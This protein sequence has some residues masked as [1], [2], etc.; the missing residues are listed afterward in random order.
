MN[1]SE[2]VTWSAELNSVYRWIHRSMWLTSAIMHWLHYILCQL[3]Q[4][5]VAQSVYIERVLVMWTTSISWHVKQRFTTQQQ[6]SLT[7]SNNN[8]VHSC[9]HQEHLK[10]LSLLPLSPHF[11]PSP[12]FIISTPVFH[13]RLL[14]CPVHFL[15]LLFSFHH[16][17]LSCPCF[18][19][20]LLSSPCTPSQYLVMGL[21]G[22]AQMKL[23][24]VYFA[25]KRVASH[26]VTVVYWWHENC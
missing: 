23:N 20:S 7:V 9:R 18:H 14:P 6:Q 19:P 1:I 2:H 8:I 16:N 4:F 26:Q 17:S 25:H 11:H 21:P 5:T 15:S 24:F 12:L 10:Y 13:T 3:L 22:R